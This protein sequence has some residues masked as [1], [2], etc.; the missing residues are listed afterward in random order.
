MPGGRH[1]STPTTSSTA[2]AMALTSMND[3]PS[4]HTSA[5]QPGWYAEVS[6]G[7]MNHP[8]LGDTPNSNVPQKNVPPITNDQKP[9]ADNRG[10]GRSRAP[11]IWG[12]SRIEIASNA[13]T[14]N[15]N[16]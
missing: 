2:D 1:L 13:G 16:I 10:N 8:P 11:R 4:N 3:S 14:A 15:R 5:P 7:Y 6:G 9:N 12:N